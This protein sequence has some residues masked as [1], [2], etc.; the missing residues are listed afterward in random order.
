MSELT[1]SFYVLQ[2]K[3][4]RLLKPADTDAIQSDDVPA[5]FWISNP[6]NTFIGNVGAGSE[7]SG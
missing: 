1:V 2:E 4:I 5:T 3:S 7:D 6:N